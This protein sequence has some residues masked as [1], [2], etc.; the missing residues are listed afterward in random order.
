MIGI[1]LIVSLLTGKDGKRYNRNFRI[2]CFV[3]KVLKVE[4][5]KNLRF[6]CECF[7]AVGCC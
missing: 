2:W 6:L 3:L 1:V 4:I 5:S 7:R